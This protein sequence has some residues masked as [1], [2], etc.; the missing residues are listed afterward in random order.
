MKTAFYSLLGAL[1]AGL[2]L[3]ALYS[4][5][6]RLDR[7]ERGKNYWTVQLGQAGVNASPV[8]R[9]LSPEDYQRQIDELDGQLKARRHVAHELRL[10]LDNKPLALP[11]T[12]EERKLRERLGP[13]S[14][15]KT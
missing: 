8:I 14:P 12:A 3:F 10:Y 11:L 4:G 6:K 1:A 7:W 13:P 2:I 5:W 15:G 9:G